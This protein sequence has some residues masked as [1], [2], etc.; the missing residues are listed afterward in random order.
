MRKPVALSATAPP[1]ADP[2]GRL[3][4][5]LTERTTDHDLRHWL[6]R[7]AADGDAPEPVR[8]AVLRRKRVLVQR[9]S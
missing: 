8:S 2:L 6:R 9:G 5:A 4:V 3:L 1:P 7:L